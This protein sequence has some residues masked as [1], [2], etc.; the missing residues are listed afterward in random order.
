MKEFIKVSRNTF[1]PNRWRNITAVTFIGC[2]TVY[3]KSLEIP[4]HQIGGEI[5]WNS[6]EKVWEKVISR[7]EIPFHQIGGEI[8]PSN[9]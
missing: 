6:N 2:M 1:P 8:I 9:R 5:T 7:L 4:F 3:R